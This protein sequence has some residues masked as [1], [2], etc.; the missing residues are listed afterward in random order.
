MEKR[1]D[2]NVGDLLYHKNNNEY[3]VITEITII[4][5]LTFVN[6][7]NLHN[8]SRSSCWWAHMDIIFINKGFTGKSLK[9]LYNKEA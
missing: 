8:T 3:W 5:Q 6:Y 1:S 7:V 2:W 4:R 9:L